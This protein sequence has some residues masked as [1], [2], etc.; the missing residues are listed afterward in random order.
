MLINTP[1]RTGYQAAAVRK[2]FQLLSTV[3]GSRHA[4][5]LTELSR[6]AGFSKSTTHGL[7]QALVQVGAIQQTERHKT[8]SLGPALF[9]MAFKGDHR[10]QVGQNTQW[11]LNDLR[12]LIG[13]SVFLG[14]ASRTKITI[15]A[16]ADA[17]KPVLRVTS[18]PGT[19]LPLL[20]GAVGKIFLALHD[21]RYALK[22]INENG[23]PRFTSRSIVDEADF[24][25]ELRKVREHGFAVDNE[26]YLPGV[27]AVA[28]NVSGG[29][30]LPMAL[31]ATGL[32]GSMH[33]GRSSPII[34][35]LLRTAKKLGTVTRSN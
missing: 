5:S 16:T 1:P 12:D 10:L 2:A 24:L 20:A 9:E 34:P 22:I 17:E 4:L 13:E 23:L 33:I 27:R 3:A 15:L 6:Q 30:G 25:E 8:F 21:D 31:W 11:L 35:A 7:I 14:G 32:A 19:T 28:V 26:E 29:R 18:R